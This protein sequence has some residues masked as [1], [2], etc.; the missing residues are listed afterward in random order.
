MIDEFKGS[1]RKK[2]WPD[3][4]AIPEFTW[5]DWG[6]HLKPSVS[7]CLGRD[8]N[9]APPRCMSIALPF[10]QPAQLLL[11]MFHS[12]PKLPYAGTAGFTQ[13]FSGDTGTGVDKRSYTVLRDKVLYKG[14][15]KTRF[16]HV[17]FVREDLYNSAVLS[18]G[19]QIIAAANWMVAILKTDR[20]I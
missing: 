20:S 2:P 9:R 1:G 11:Q 4:G 3:Q 7:W 14:C 10:R 5:R 8:Y 15:S 17:T 16:L 6:I 19:R 13:Y 18:S 12:G